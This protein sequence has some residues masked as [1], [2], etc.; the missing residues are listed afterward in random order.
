MSLAVR[1]SGSGFWLLLNLWFL[2]LFLV[3]RNQGLRQKQEPH[4]EPEPESE[5][6]TRTIAPTDKRHTQTLDKPSEKRTPT[7]APPQPYLARLNQKPGLGPLQRAEHRRRDS[8]SSHREG[9]ETLV[10]VDNARVPTG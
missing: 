2:L 1:V 3:G 6:E 7:K 5:T 9:H 10:H 4:I 8:S